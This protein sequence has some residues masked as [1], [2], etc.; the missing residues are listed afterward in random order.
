MKNL[1]DNLSYYQNQK[2]LIIDN[3]E[4]Y[5]SVRYYTEY[6]SWQYAGHTFS[7]YEIL[8]EHGT[9]WWY[10]IKWGRGR[11]GY[12]M[13]DDNWTKD[14]VRKAIAKKLN[15]DIEEISSQ[16]A[17]SA[18]GEDPTHW[19]GRKDKMFNTYTVG[20]QHRRSI[21][22]EEVYFDQTKYE[23]A[24]SEC[25]QNIINSQAAI[26][27]FQINQTRGQITN[28]QNEISALSQKIRIENTKCQDIKYKIS[29]VQNTNNLIR[30][31][32]NDQH[33]ATY[34]M[35]QLASEDQRAFFLFE[36]FGKQGSEFVINT[37]K[38]LGFNANYLAYLA[39]QKSHNEL[40]ELS[41]QYGAD[42]CNHFVENRTLLQHLLHGNNDAFV[43]K[44]LSK[45]KNL[46]STLVNAISQ[47][48]LV[49]LEKLLSK[50]PSLL[51]QKYAGY[52]LLQIAI[53]AE[54]AHSEVIKKILSFDS[55]AAEI[56]TSNGESALKIA[57]RCGSPTEIIKIIAEH[58]N[59]RLEINQLGAKASNLEAQDIDS[60]VKIFATEIAELTNLDNTSLIGSQNLDLDNSNFMV[61]NY[62][63][64]GG[65]NSQDVNNE[66]N[67]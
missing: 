45:N 15:R 61:T 6:G 24:L 14:S 30:D 9:S 26:I 8:S 65:L 12:H 49:S 42:F 29:Q 25:E 16:V 21:P 31:K 17:I 43:Q 63:S 35:L 58:A 64:L 51:K 28:K 52:S 38:S 67:I 32:I 34:N 53:A 55:K 39:L 36:L 50:D 13:K 41:L 3:K 37:I 59:L 66:H 23:K 22:K 44:I 57:V 40:L 60:V 20:Y 7:G 48:D 2:R 62:V 1:Q 54:G 33:K 46:T 27:D 56:L 5:T 10:P 11:F 4:S 47:D 18:R 19:F